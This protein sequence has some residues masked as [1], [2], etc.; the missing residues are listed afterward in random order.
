MF[1]GVDDY[2]AVN[3]L[4]YSS[5]LEEVTVCA[6]VKSD[7]SQ[8]VIASWDRSEYWR[9]GIGSDGE[10]GTVTWNTR[11]STIDDMSGSSRV[12]DGRW[13]HLCVSYDSGSSEKRIY[14]DG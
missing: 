3:G 9:F 8:Q 7:K 6:W 4:E 2:I 14:V 10:A 1:D 11:A 13:H 5:P 12:D